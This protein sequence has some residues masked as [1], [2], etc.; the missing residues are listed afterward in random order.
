MSFVLA[1]IQ[2]NI[3]TLHTCSLFILPS[4]L[5]LSEVFS[6]NVLESLEKI[7]FLYQFPCKIRTPFTEIIASK[8]MRKVSVEAD[9]L[10]QKYHSC[11][12]I[13]YHLNRLN[14]FLS[15]N[16][17][18]DWCC[19]VHYSVDDTGLVDRTRLSV[20]QSKIFYL[21]IYPFIISGG[22]ICR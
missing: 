2:E 6:W 10:L 11:S 19:V 16:L 7:N 14:V 12:M 13:G 3:L 21:Y 20:W 22:T 5:H 15:K 8:I 1:T 17:K 9:K 18:K 4:K